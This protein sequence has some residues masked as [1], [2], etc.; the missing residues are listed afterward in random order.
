MRTMDTF[1]T[2]AEAMAGRLRRLLNEGMLALVAGMG[3]RDGWLDALAAVGPA[4]APELARAAGAAEE[5]V[6]PWLAALVAG[7][8][9]DFDGARDTY[10]VA[11][12]LGALLASEVGR[13]YR[14]GLDELVALAVG[15]PRAPASPEILPVAELGAIVPG[16][17]E[18]LARGADVVA[19]TGLGA[20]EAEGAVRALAPGGVAIVA[21]PP[22]SG[23][24]SDDA[25]HPVGAFL[26]GARALGASPELAAAAAG[27]RL[28][29]AG[30]TIDALARLPSDP[31]RDYLVAH[32]PASPNP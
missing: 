9:L 18:R 6:R 25:L 32:K 26:L 2:R 20:D 31:F 23:S 27:A 14:R 8:L 15:A 13:A 17:A 22:L 7:R 1:D 28:A 3:S 12:D 30:L 19:L 16:L 5:R 4:T 21:V 29:R 24:P 10:A 11:P